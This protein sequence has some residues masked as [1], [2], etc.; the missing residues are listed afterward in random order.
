METRKG[1]VM[2]FSMRSVCTRFNGQFVA[3]IHQ[4]RFGGVD[5]AWPQGREIGFFDGA[6]SHDFYATVVY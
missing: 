6:W 1:S 2:L 5:V 4:N 3:K